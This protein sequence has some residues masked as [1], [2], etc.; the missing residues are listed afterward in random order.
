MYFIAKQLYQ[1]CS[2]SNRLHILSIEGLGDIINCMPTLFVSAAAPMMALE[3][4]ET[5][6]TFSNV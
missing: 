1:F 2:I 5:T 3:R 6:N 4:L